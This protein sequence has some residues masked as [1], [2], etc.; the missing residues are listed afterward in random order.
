MKTQ[1][2]D[3]S[4]GQKQ[5]IE[6]LQAPATTLLDLLPLIKKDRLLTRSILKI[7]NSSYYAIPET[8]SDVS[9]A[10]QYIGYN[11]LAQIVLTVHVF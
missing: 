1:T 10:L 5:I 8:V 11:H 2:P 7:V 9:A 4:N 6:M 3:F